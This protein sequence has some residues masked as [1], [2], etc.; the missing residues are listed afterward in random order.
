[1][2]KLTSL[3]GLLNCTINAVATPPVAAESFCPNAIKT[4]QIEVVTIYS[5]H[6]KTETFFGYEC[7]EHLSYRGDTDCLLIENTTI[8][9]TKPTIIRSELQCK[10]EIPENLNLDKK[11]K[12]LES[13]QRTGFNL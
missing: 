9:L 6:S 1:M 10:R 11:V 4:S 2:K 13:I 5:T 12:T 3:I 8:Q 7:P